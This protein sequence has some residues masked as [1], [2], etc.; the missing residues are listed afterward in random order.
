MNMCVPPHSALSLQT[1]YALRV[2]YIFFILFL[3]FELQKY[4]GSPLSPL[5]NTA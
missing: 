5:L 1:R 4:C 2:I 3:G